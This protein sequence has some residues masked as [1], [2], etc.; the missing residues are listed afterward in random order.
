MTRNCD[1]RFCRFLLVV[2]TFG[3]YLLCLLGLYAELIYFISLWSPVKEEN[4]VDND[5]NNFSEPSK[6]NNR[7]LHLKSE[8]SH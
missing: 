6:L 4:R 2:K 1:K 8:T 3:N 7:T 5:P